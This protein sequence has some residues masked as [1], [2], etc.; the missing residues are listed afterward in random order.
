MLMV[1][2]GRGMEVVLVTPHPSKLENNN[3]SS[4]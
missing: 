4:I 1:P 3:E 2:W